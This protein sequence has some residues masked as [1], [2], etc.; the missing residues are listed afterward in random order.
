MTHNAEEEKKKFFTFIRSERKMIARI[1]HHRNE[2][3][4]FIYIIEN[5]KRSHAHQH[6]KGF[7]DYVKCL[8]CHVYVYIH[9]IL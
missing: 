2:K 5:Y 8:S 7:S 6:F 9:S 3:Q 1:W 4:F